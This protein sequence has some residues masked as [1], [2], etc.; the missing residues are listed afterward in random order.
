MHKNVQNKSNREPNVVHTL[1][2]LY[3]HGTSRF[4]KW[5]FLMIELQTES[6]CLSSAEIILCSGPEFSIKTCI[7]IIIIF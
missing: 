2:N 5:P 3:S 6:C 7:C 1:K 4:N